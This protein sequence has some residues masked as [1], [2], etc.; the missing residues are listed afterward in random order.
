[1]SSSKLLILIR[2]GE[3]CDFTGQVP[4]FGQY[5]PEL[6]ENGKTY[7]FKTG[8]LL[9]QKLELLLILLHEYHSFH[10]FLLLQFFLRKLYLLLF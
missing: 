4:V 7:A 1:M 6:T 2:H 5:D 8:K 10:Q 3:R 9:S